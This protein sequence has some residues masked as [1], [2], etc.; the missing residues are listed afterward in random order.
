MKQSKR[1]GVVL[2][3]C[4]VMDGAEIHESVITLLAIDQEN[5]EAICMAPDMNQMHVMNHLTSTEMKGETRNVLVESAR[6][7]RGKIRNI[8]DVKADEID[9]LIFP[10]GFGAAKNLSDFAI[11]GENCHVHPEVVRLVREV[12]K[13]KKPI[14][15]V[16]ISPAMMAK[17]GQETGKRLKLTI[18]NDSDTASALRKMGIDHVDAAVTDIVVDEEHKMVSTPAYMLAERI[19]E[20]STGIGKLVKAVIGMS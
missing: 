3:G 4:G 9:A 2:S 5:A 11:K 20:A 12:I 17:I 16:C 1:I 13:A 8:R 19:S 15:V 6:I 10:G 14:G 7:A 18:G